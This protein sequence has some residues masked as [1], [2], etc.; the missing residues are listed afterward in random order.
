VHAA[1]ARPEVA[2]HQQKSRHCWRLFCS[3]VGRVAVPPEASCEGWRPHGDWLLRQTGASAAHARLGRAPSPV[4][5]LL[6]S[7]FVLIPVGPPTKKPPKMAAFNRWRPH[8]DSNPGVER[9]P[10]QCVR[11]GEDIHRRHPRTSASLSVLLSHTVGA[12][13]PSGGAALSPSKEIDVSEK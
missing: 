5:P 6:P 8:G 3:L 10:T 7:N 2:L 13:H 11:Q 12:C 9:T 1:T 4:A